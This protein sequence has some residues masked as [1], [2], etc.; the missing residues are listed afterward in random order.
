MFDERTGMLIDN[1]DV[2]K[3]DR[4][5]DKQTF[6]E[7]MKEYGF[8]FTD[9]DE[10]TRLPKSLIPVVAQKVEP[11]IL[12]NRAILEIHKKKIVP[13][14]DSISYL[15]EDYFDAKEVLRLLQTVT[16]NYIHNDLGKKFRITSQ[17][18]SN[19]FGAFIY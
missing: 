12:F 10:K 3:Q 2:T 13:I 7:A 16:L 4:K 18:Q 17:D 8:D 1:S 14:T 15:V 5:H 11:F 9:I 19:N 6:Y